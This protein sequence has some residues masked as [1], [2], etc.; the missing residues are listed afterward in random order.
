[1]RNQKKLDK[2]LINR[3]RLALNQSGAMYPTP[4]ALAPFLESGETEFSADILRAWDVCRIQFK[5]FETELKSKFVQV[6]VFRAFVYHLA[7]YL[8]FISFCEKH[9]IPVS[10]YLYGHTK[11]FRREWSISGITGERHLERFKR[12]ALAESDKG[13]YLE[14]FFKEMHTRI[15]DS[16]SGV[17]VKRRK[18]FNAG[19][20]YISVAMRKTYLSAEEII[21]LDGWRMPIGFLISDPRVYQ[22]HRE[23]R[24]SPKVSQRFKSGLEEIRDLGLMG[25]FF[26]AMSGQV[27]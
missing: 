25:E 3:A 17:L 21:I 7:G 27:A 24:L 12:W 10:W 1:M 19:L 14:E 15:G 26:G 4:A 18:E 11:I 13:I 2:G 6:K 22:L 8:R 20:N 23:N 9:A 5:I 16:A